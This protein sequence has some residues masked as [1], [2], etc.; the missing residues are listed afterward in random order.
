M[1][2][3]RNRRPIPLYLEPLES[4][5]LLSASITQIFTPIIGGGL[6]D[7]TIAKISGI[8]PAYY[9]AD[10]HAQVTWDDGEVT[11]AQFGGSLSGILSLYATTPEGVGTHTGHVDFYQD[12]PDSPGAHINQLSFDFSEIINQNSDGGTTITGQPNQSI[13]GYLGTLKNRTLPGNPQGPVTGPFYGTTDPSVP[14]TTLTGVGISWGDGTYGDA[15][16]IA[17]PNGGYDVY[18]THTYAGAGTYRISLGA[19]ESAAF[20]PNYDGPPGFYA[21]PLVIWLAD[22]TES[23]ALISA[24]P[25]T[26]PLSTTHT[27]DTKL[28]EVPAQGDTPRPNLTLPPGLT[29]T[30][31]NIIT[32]NWGD[33][34]SS[35]ATL[36]ANDHGSFDL[37]AQHTFTTD[38][39]YTLKIT[40]QANTLTDYNLPGPYTS[41]GPLDFSLTLVVTD[42]GIILQSTTPD[43]LFANAV[44][45]D[46]TTTP[47]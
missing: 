40:G 47:S 1:R 20:N 32:I 10:L 7:N 33:N 16:L 22:R 30:S 31:V 15:T 21:I 39:T 26:P 11:P 18:G 2:N 36:I 35:D 46:S 38:G 43:T 37:V 29:A 14:T 41:T 44:T 45:L 24:D 28:T 9:F 5:Q 17:N 4:R 6:G 27:L 25:A 19:S 13:S 8:T 42:S 12:S 3:P 34:S 23:T